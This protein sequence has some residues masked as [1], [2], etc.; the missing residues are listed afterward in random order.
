ME[1]ENVIYINKSKLSFKIKDK[2]KT[3]LEN[4][5]SSNLMLPHGCKS[6]SCGS[7][8]AKLIR[9]N[10]TL[11]N[12]AFIIENEEILLCQSYLISEEMVLEYSIDQIKI[13]EEKYNLK[14]KIIPKDYLLQ[15]LSNKSV[16]P[17]VKEVSLHVP[18]KLN[19]KFL[20][21][22]HM[23]FIYPN[24]ELKREYSIVNSPNES[25]KLADN[26]FRFLIVC[27]HEGGLS[28]IIHNKVK[29][30]DLF[31]LRGPF[32]SFEYKIDNDKPLIG[33]AGGTGIAPI[34]SVVKDALVKNK[35]LTVLIFLSVRNRD[36][37]LEMETL[38]KLK[39]E[40]INFSFKITLSRE[41]EQPNSI[42]LYGR[43]NTTLQ[44]VFKDLSTHKVL[45][46][47]SEGFVDNMY[48]Y[49]ISLNAKKENIFFEKFS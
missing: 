31:K 20:P 8:T 12:N 33:I 16:S 7:C 2:S 49:T 26:I 30:G 27:H 36:E 45:I 21:G 43:V 17:M 48:N 28:S 3:I 23:E 41:T 29:V 11:K 32:A 9:G 10:A 1:K 24:K 14:D 25:M 19:F 38:M 46:A 6:G 18:P 44:K 47:G 42:F 39:D 35:K 4:A 5:L 15:V 34:L 40:Y 22:S 13:I 37:I